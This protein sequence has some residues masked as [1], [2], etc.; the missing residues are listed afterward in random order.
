MVNIT[1]LTVAGRQRAKLSASGG[2]V[3]I[4]KNEKQIGLLQLLCF[5]AVFVDGS[6]PGF[7]TG[8]SQSIQ[9][10]SFNSRITFCVTRGATP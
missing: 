5:V 3:A 8:G 9:F 10:P 4:R 2:R 1:N 7:E 6:I